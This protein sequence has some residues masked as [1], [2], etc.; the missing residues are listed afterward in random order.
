MKKFIFVLTALFM[1]GLT[2]ARAEYSSMAV[3]GKDAKLNNV[4]QIMYNN[5]GQ[6]ITANSVVILDTSSSATGT[7]LTLGAYITTSTT[8]GSQ[9]IVGV[10]DQDIA[11]G[12]VGRICVR[13]A[14]QVHMVAT[15]TVGYIV[16]NAG[17][18]SNN[19]SADGRG[20]TFVNTGAPGTAATGG[21]LGIAL[22]NAIGETQWVYVNPSSVWR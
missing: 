13:G 14:H 20:V 17:S 15:A 4:F 3:T 12:S 9:Y 21:V 22:S 11:S 5:K 8:T 19:L 16:T 6:T 2:Q 7:D 10:A 1:F 18:A